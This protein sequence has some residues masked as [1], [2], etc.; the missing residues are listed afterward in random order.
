MTTGVGDNGAG[1][2]ATDLIGRLSQISSRT[3]L[4]AIDSVL[5]ALSH[6][7]VARTASG[8]A[9]GEGGVASSAAVANDA[10]STPTVADV[11]RE[12]G[13]IAR[14]MVTTTEDFAATMKTR[15]A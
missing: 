4:M 8:L 3:S 7:A 14:R 13:V 12:V 15:S 10:L 9:T 5:R 11:A 6:P 1:Q 2:D